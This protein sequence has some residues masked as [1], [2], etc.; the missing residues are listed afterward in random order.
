MSGSPELRP[1]SLSE[2]LDRGFK[3]AVRNYGRLVAIAAAVFLPVLLLAVLFV[4]V[5]MPEVVAVIDGK[6]YFVTDEDLDA[7][8][9]TVLIA[10]GFGVLGYLFAIAAMH[11]A[12]G[13]V[14]L[15]ETRSVGESVRMTGA[16][17]GHI[18]L[19]LLG[20]A[21]GLI[22]PVALAAVV[23]LAISPVLGVFLIVAA[24]VA[25]YWFFVASSLALAVV[26]REQITGI[27]AIRRSVALIRG[28]WLTAFGLYILTGILLG[29]V[30]AIISAVLEPAFAVMAGDSVTGVVAAS[31]APT[32]VA[33][34]ATAPILVSIV[35][36][37][38][39]DLRVRK[40]GYDLEMLARESGIVFDDAPAPVAPRAPREPRLGMPTMASVPAQPEPLPPPLAPMP[41]TE[42]PPGVRGPRWSEPL[43]GE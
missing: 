1:L 42:N 14:Y 23:G 38:Y 29:I 32:V 36:V 9:V 3:I 40:E 6:F 26:M 28:K 12:V 30:S 39:F 41:P 22:V 21:I 2:V 18:L 11:F 13:D 20:T 10:A 8:G 37:F 4:K 34:L 25:A 24:S 5:R 31:V 27:D 17:F 19:V 33:E 35:T 15:D 43:G 7:F 16:R